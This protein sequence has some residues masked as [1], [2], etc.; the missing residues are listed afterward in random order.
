MTADRRPW[1]SERLSRSCPADRARCRRGGG[2]LAIRLGCGQRSATTTRPTSE[3]RAAAVDGQ[4]LYD[5]SIDADR[6][7]RALL[8]PA[9]VRPPR[10]PR[11]RCSPPRLDVDRLERSR[12][13]RLRRGGRGSCRSRGRSAGCRSCSAGLS[14][15]VVY[16]VKLGPG[17][18]APLP[19][20]RDRLALD[21][22]A[23]AARGRRSPR[24]RSSRSSRRLLLVWAALTRRWAAIAVGLAVLI[25]A[26]ALVATVVRRPRLRGATT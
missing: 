5:T 6:R 9:A 18:A 14:W 16:A 19:V 17:R 22:P 13:R 26:A 7:I 1:R 21:R 25:A 10:R 12:S 4:P 15:P 8:L 24:G 20:L 2:R 3:R 11:S 23:G